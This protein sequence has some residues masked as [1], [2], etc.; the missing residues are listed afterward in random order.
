MLARYHC[1]S[2]FTHHPD[3]NRTK[4][5]RQGQQMPRNPSA[6]E[7]MVSPGPFSQLPMP[8]DPS[9]PRQES[10][11]SRQARVPS[12][13]LSLPFLG[14]KGSLAFRPLIHNA[15]EGSLALRP[16]LPRRQSECGS[17]R[18]SDSSSGSSMEQTSPRFLPRLPRTS[19]CGDMGSSC[20]G[21]PRARWN[22]TG[23]GS[24]QG[25]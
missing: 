4:S 7:G 21:S 15:S 24:L 17:R 11:S 25:P 19:D 20:T 10:S 22:Y 12:R 13:V 18:S 23:S 2:L 8:G 6:P 3:T 14:S 16:S 1:V 5:Q 9:S